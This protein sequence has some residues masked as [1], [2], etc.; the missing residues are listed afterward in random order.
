MER[1]TGAIRFGSINRKLNYHKWN[2]FLCQNG[3]AGEAFPQKIN[4][5]KSLKS[6]NHTIYS[7]MD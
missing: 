7:Q 5:L 6:K 4:R 3:G 2:N 1:M